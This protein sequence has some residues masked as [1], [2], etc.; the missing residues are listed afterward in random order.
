MPPDDRSSQS[1]YQYGSIPGG[2]IE[3]EVTDKAG[4]EKAVIGVEGGSSHVG[5]P[6]IKERPTYE[7]SFA[8]Q[9]MSGFV[10]AS[11]S[12]WGVWISVYYTICAISDWKK[13]NIA[14]PDLYT[15]DFPVA[16]FA[17][18]FHLIGAAFMALAG[19]FQLVKYIRKTYPVF[20]RWVGRIYIMSS[21]I[22]SIGGLV[23]IFAKGDYGGRPADYA[24]ATYGFI[25]LLC[26]IMAYYRAIRK[27]FVHHKLWAWRLYSLSLAAWMYRFDYYW[28]MELFGIGTNSWIHSE[29]FQGPIDK[30]I[31]WA[32]YVPNLIVVEIIFRWGENATL[33]TFLARV[34]D[35]SYYIIFVMAVIYTAHA[36]FQLWLPSILGT[37]DS[38]W[39][40]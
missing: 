19:A 6:I 33:P 34:L 2:D 26:G 8:F 4:D 40:L 39:I 35:V 5:P 31:N 32:F 1:R 11:M 36:F 10:W 12:V 9:L 20:H 22:A 3:N 21:M 29:S 24:F 14:F 18:C 38:G 37:Y 30:Y 23:F 27:Q 16:S 15:P 7:L 13:F 28:W 25:F 17:I